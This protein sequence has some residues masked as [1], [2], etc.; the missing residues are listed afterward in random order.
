MSSLQKY[1]R[2]PHLPWSRP[3]ESDI[4]MEKDFSPNTKVVVTEKLDGENTSI[5]PDGKVHAR[6]MDSRDHPSRHWIKAMAA[7][8]TPLMSEGFVLLGENVF[9]KHSIGYDSLTSYFYLFGIRHGEYMASWASVCAYAERLGLE[10]APVIW[11][12]KWKD[13]NHDDIWPR[14]SAFGPNCEGYVVR[15][16]SAI[17]LLHFRQS[18]AKY[19]RPNHVQTN[20]HWMHQQVQKNG[21]KT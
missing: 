12:G 14:E 5:Y 13:F 3:D 7:G 18:I 4:W 9:A 8:I 17:H 6:S 21:L 1:P 15:K 19:V 2:T 11:E 20:K 10:T 16:K